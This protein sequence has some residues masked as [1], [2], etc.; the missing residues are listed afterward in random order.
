M[1]KTH[2]HKFKK[3]KKYT[4]NHKKKRAGG[5]KSSEERKKE[6]ETSAK[7]TVKKRRKVKLIIVEKFDDKE[8]EAG[9]KEIIPHKQEDLKIEEERIV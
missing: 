9:T 3:I 1:V 7:K 4:R 5:T 8:I 6:K 2:K